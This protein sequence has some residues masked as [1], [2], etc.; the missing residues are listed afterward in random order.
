MK[1]LETYLAELF[2]RHDLVVLPGFGAFI[3]RRKPA[4]IDKEIGLFIPP[5]KEISFNI[6]INKNDGLLINYIVRKENLSYGEAGDFVRN[7]IAR[8]K[9]DLQTHHTLHLK[10]IGFFHL[11][12][13]KIIFTPYGHHNFLSEAYGLHPFLRKTLETST[14]PAEPTFQPVSTTTDEPVSIQ[15][16]PEEQLYTELPANPLPASGRG[17]QWLKYA[18]AIVLLLLLLFGGYQAN[19]RHWN[20]GQSSTQQAGYTLPERLPALVIT[21]SKDEPKTSVNTYTKPPVHTFYY[22]IIGAFKNKKNA[23]QLTERLRSA[24]INASI[25][26]QNAEGLYYVAYATYND[27]QSAETLLAKVKKQYPGAWIWER[28]L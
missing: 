19:R 10:E 26:G 27:I 17:I 12:G 3:G 7:E 6:L 23:M 14:T 11:S 1:K 8:W 25:P 24:G 28:Q 13:E 2:Y 22:I 5:S 16:E 9:N 15:H 18:A 21:A 4:H 20:I